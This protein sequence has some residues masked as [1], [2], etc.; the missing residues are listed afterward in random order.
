MSEFSCGWSG[1]KMVHNHVNKF[2]PLKLAQSFR[3]P[4]QCKGKDMDMKMRKTPV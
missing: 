2:K 1:L 3:E 4:P